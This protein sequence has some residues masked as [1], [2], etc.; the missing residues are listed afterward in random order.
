MLHTISQNPNDAH[1]TIEYRAI[2]AAGINEAVVRQISISNNDPDWMLALRLEAL[3]V[4]QSKSLPT[5][6]PDLSKLDLY[7]IYYFAKPEGS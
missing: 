3:A 1:D 6:G 4:F 7:S 5:W 2:S